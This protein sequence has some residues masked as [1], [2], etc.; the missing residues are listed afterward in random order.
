MDESHWYRWSEGNDCPF[1]RPRAESNEYWDLVRSLPVSSLYLSSNQT[2]RGHCLLIWDVRHAIRIDQL[3]SREW[4]AFCADLFVAEN[5]IVETLNPDHINVEI[6]GNV[7]PHL[8]WQII[9]R[10]RTDPRWEAPVWTTTVAE[11]PVNKLSASDRGG[12]IE[13]L[14]EALGKATGGQPDE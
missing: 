4:L 10:Y 9:P 5:A 14:R 2:Y 11:M 6:L 12:L 3:S 13:R 1:D 7:V 8:H